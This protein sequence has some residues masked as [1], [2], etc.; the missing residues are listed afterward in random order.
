[1]NKKYCCLKVIIVCYFQNC[2]YVTK[3]VFSDDK[4]DIDWAYTVFSTL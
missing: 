4:K 2:P 1:M 3:N